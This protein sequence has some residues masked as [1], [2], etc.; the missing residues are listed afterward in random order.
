MADDI[1]RLPG[2]VTT[3]Y[4][5][6]REAFIRLE[7]TEGRNHLHGLL[8]FRNA[9]ESLAQAARAQSPSDED[10]LKGQA[11]DELGRVVTWDYERLARQNLRVIRWMTATY[12][13][14]GLVRVMPD[15]AAIDHRI[16]QVSTLLSFGTPSF[17]H[18]TEESRGCPDWLDLSGRLEEAY[19]ISVTA[20]RE[21][22]HGAIRT[23]RLIAYAATVAATVALALALGR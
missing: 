23:D 7:E 4:C 1:V 21:L 15:R 9:L 18:M 20:R 6:A 19:L 16:D 8:F 12:L 3:L 14:G 5:H 22:G 2:D 13:L 11:I 17:G 10:D